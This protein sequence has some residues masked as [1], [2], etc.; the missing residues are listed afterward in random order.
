MEL[1]HFSHKHPLVFVEER[2]HESDK[3]YCSGCGELVIGP[4]FSCTE[5]G[6]YLDKQCAEAPR[7]MNHPFHRNHSLNLLVSAPYKDGAFI[8]DFCDKMGERF[9]YHCSC[10]LDFH[11]KCALFSYNI[12]EKRIAEFQHIPRIDPLISTENQIK[13]L[14]KAKCFA[15]WKPLLEPVYFS[16]DCG[17]YLHA[18]CADLSAEVNHLLHHQ[19]PLILQFNSQRLSCNLC[20]E[21]QSRGLVYCCSLCMF[22]LH[23]ECAAIPT[24]INNPFHRKHP[25]ILQFKHD[26]DLPCQICQET[27][28]KQI[29]YCCLVCKFALHIECASPP[30]VI[31]DKN[32]PHPFILFWRHFSFICDACGMPGNHVSYICSTCGLLVHNKCISLPRTLKHPMHPEHPISHTYFL[33]Q[34]EVESWEC[35]IC[36]LED[37]NSKHGGYYCSDCNYISHVNCAIEDYNWYEID[38]SER[39]ENLEENSALLLPYSIVKETKDGENVVAAEIKHFTHEHN[40]VLSNDIKD[41][42]CCDGCVLTIFTSYYYCPQCD[43][44]LHKGC[45]ELPRKKHLWFDPHPKLHPLTLGG[46]F[47]CDLCDYETSGFAYT[48]DKCDSSFCIKCAPVSDVAR[49]EGHKHPLFFYGK[50]EGLCNACGDSINNAHRC[51]SCN[52]NLDDICLTLPLIAQHK[53]D[54]HPLKLTYHDNN[55]YSECDYCDICEEERNPSHWFYHCAICNNSA[56]PKCVLGKY[57]FIK[58]GSIYKEGDHT[59][60]IT[61]VQKVHYYPEC[62]KCNKPCLDLALECKTFGCSY[63]VHWKCIKPDS[64]KEEEEEDEEEEKE[65][66]EEEE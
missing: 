12:A 61:F 42:K 40:L 63:I 35:R 43:F 27:K 56:H 46:I 58:H 41:D 16:P 49:C 62:H 36:H 21:I 47:R 53:Y 28:H 64:L 9:V 31:E 24:Q 33:G 57:S 15:C 7:E 32:H 8:C 18:K 30:P 20:Q 44:C 11:I 52:F 4:S 22:I 60:P 55:N 23:I 25:L 29:L 59:H 13:T 2:S 6:F 26:G 45:A 38:E 66:D 17:F 5:C 19:H 10:G 51:K 65:E 39:D 34:Y 14:K 37:V 48:C 50:Y 3:V 54:E 1:Q